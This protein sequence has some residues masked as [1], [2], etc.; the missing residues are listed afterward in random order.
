MINVAIYIYDDAEVLDFS[1]PYEVFSTAARLAGSPA[2]FNTFLL[3]QNSGPVTARAGYRVL[4]HYSFDDCPQVDLLIVV[5]GVHNAEMEKP[6][7]ISWLAKCAEQAK[8]VASVCTGAFLLAKGEVITQQVVT[9]HWEDVAD[10]ETQFPALR[11]KRD[12]RWVEHGRV[13]TSAG[14]SAGL[15]M[16][17]H[18]VQV[19]QSAELAERTAKQMD[20]SWDKSTGVTW[21][22]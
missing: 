3:A 2:V 4:P 20:Y 21:L 5:G 19:L 11:V 8:W 17:L 7:V 22:D 14:I 10:L 16:S 12:V 15:D 6:Q 13:F 18:L 9:T 1:G